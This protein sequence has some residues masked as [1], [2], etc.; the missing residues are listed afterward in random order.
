M[1][2]TQTKIKKALLDFVNSKEIDLI[3]SNTV[4]EGDRYF[5]LDPQ[6]NIRIYLD[7]EKSIIAEAKG[8][9]E[10]GFTEYKN[11]Y[12]LQKN[13]KSKISNRK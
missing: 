10:K 4:V 5:I 2:A 11:F 8:N 6:I 1:N 13:L 3:L 7:R 9:S 12:P